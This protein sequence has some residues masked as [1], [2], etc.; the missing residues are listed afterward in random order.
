MGNSFWIKQAVDLILA[1]ISNQQESVQLVLGDSSSEVDAS[2]PVEHSSFGLSELLQPLREILYQDADLA[3]HLWVQIFPQLWKAL[4][5]VATLDE[6][7]NC[8]DR[9]SKFFT[10]FLSKDYHNKQ[11]RIQP[12]VIQALLEGLSACWPIPNVPIEVIKFLGKTYNAWH[13]SI[14]ILEDRL[15]DGTAMQNASPTSVQEKLALGME[16][17]TIGI[18]S[19]N[20]VSPSFVPCDLALAELYQLLSEDD[21]FYS[22][23]KRRAA[24]EDTKAAIIL[25]QHGMWQKAQEVYFNVMNKTHSGEIAFVKG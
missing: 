5:S 21:L 1:V 3:Y 15:S 17:S 9:L 12:N 8:H 25:E 10:N 14:K 20:F 22:I 6:R 7:D 11:Q 13:V 19:Q 24:V 16:E 18:G 4:P 23:W 2:L